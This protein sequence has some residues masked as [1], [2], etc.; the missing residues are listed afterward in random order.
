MVCHANLVMVAWHT[1]I[2]EDSVSVILTETPIASTTP[3]QVLAVDTTT[4]PLADVNLFFWL[5]KPAIHTDLFLTFVV[6]FFF[7]VN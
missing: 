7:D 1:Q 3:L 2:S 4:A 5:I 6:L